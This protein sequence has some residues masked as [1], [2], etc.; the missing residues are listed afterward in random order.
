[1]D[2]QHLHQGLWYV[3]TEFVKKRMKTNLMNCF[4]VRLQI[5]TLKQNFIKPFLNQENNS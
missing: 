2:K 4:S 3:I 5:V 1:M